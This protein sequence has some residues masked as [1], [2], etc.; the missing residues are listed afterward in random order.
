MSSQES[1][2]FKYLG[3]YNDQKSNV[4]TLHQIPYINELKECDIEKSHKELQNAK[5]TDS[6]AQQLRGLAGQ[7]NWSLA[8]TRPDMSYHECEV[9]TSVKE[10]KIIDLK[11]KAIPKLKSSEVTLKFHNLG[12]LEK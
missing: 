5:L 12:D 8:Q 9:S 6:E 11:S 7:L 3:L 4:I 2:T 1:E 10:G